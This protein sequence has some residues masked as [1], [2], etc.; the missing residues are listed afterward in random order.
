M[1]N[2]AVLRRTV[3]VLGIGAASVS[4]ALPFATF[5]IFGATVPAAKVSAGVIPGLDDPIIDP[6]DVE[7]GNGGFGD[8]IFPPIP[9]LPEIPPEDVEDGTGGVDG[10]IP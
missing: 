8:P 9:P 1:L 7:D 3:A 2:S 5:A 4:P 10:S 6:E